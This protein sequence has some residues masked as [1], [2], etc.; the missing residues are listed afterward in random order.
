MAVP[1]APRPLASARGMNRNKNQVDG[2]TLAQIT[3]NVKSP[4]KA[5]RQHCLSCSCGCMSEVRLCTVQTCELFPYRFGSNPN[6]AGIGRKTPTQRGIS[7]QE[8]ARLSVGMGGI[9]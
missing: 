5:I 1:D 2:N 9:S 6:R 7:G 3:R 8:C 4:L